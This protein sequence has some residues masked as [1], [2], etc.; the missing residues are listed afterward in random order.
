MINHLYSVPKA[1]ISTPTRHQKSSNLN[2]DMQKL[3]SHFNF[4]YFKW[5][6]ALDTISLVLQTYFLMQYPILLLVKCSPSTIIFQSETPHSHRSRCRVW[7]MHLFTG[8]CKNLQKKRIWVQSDFYSFYN[9]NNFYLLYT[10][11]VVNTQKNCKYF[12]S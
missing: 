7:A 8:T 11:F 10:S 1:L 2:I 6:K 5:S 9:L 3:I 4:N 12:G